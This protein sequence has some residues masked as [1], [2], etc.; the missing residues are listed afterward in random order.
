VC[1]C[2][3]P[4]LNTKPY[5]LKNEAAKVQ[6]NNGRAKK[7]GKLNFILILFFFACAKKNQ[8]STPENEY[9]PFSGKEA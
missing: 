5:R 8:K 4:W 7:M 9:S 3:Q 1:N 2:C 6:K